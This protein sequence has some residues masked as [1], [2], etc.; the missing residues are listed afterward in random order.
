[1]AVKSRE[2]ELRRAELIGIGLVEEGR[3]LDREE[4]VDWNWK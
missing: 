2:E 4:R 1:L 3:F